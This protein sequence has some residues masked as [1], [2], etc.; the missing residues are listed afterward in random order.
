MITDKNSTA[1]YTVH[2]GKGFKCNML[3]LRNARKLM[4]RINDC[5]SGIYHQYS[6]AYI[7]YN[8]VPSDVIRHED[9][10]DDQVT[11]SLIDLLTTGF[12]ERVDLAVS[13]SFIDEGDLSLESVYMMLVDMDSRDELLG[14]SYNKAC[15]NTVRAKLLETYWSES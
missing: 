2:D 13:A 15:L 6:G 14:I 4:R 1:P 9:L 3:A 8:V 5:H 12:N 7:E 11:Q 10:F